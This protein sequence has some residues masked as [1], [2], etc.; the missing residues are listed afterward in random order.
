M[1]R[2]TYRYILTDHHIAVPCEDL[3]TWARWFEIPG[4][5]I[6]RQ[7]RVGPILVSTVFLGLDT[8]LG[9]GDPVLFETAV[10]EAEQAPCWTARYCAWEEAVRGHEVTVGATRGY[11]GLVAAELSAETNG[12]F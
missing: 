11:V 2:R 9:L 8:S 5:T 1:T 4:N 3:L 10:F 12:K 6:V 7:T